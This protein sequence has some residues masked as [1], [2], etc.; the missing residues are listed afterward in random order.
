MTRRDR[1]KERDMRMKAQRRTTRLFILALATTVAAGGAVGAWAGG[2]L[3]HA[4]PAAKTARAAQGRQAPIWV[5]GE[6]QRTARGHAVRVTSR[7]PGATTPR[8]RATARPKAKAKVKAKVKATTTRTLTPRNATRALAATATI[9]LCATAGTVTIGTST[10]P[11]WGFALKGVAANC[12]G[13]TA[14]LPGP[15]LNV[16]QG[17]TVTLAIT[18]AL[19]GS[20]TISV[21]APG[22]AF[23]AGSLDAAPG[24]TVSA[25]FT[26]GSEGTY[27]YESSGDAGRQEAMGLYGALV[28]HSATAGQAYGSAFD[29][30]QVVVLSELDANLNASPDTF[31]MNNWDPTYW[32]LNGKASPDTAPIGAAAGQRVLLRYANAGMDNNT[33]TLLGVR[34]RLI[35]RDAYPLANPFSVVSETFA[36]GQTAD[37]LVT[38]PASASSGAKFALYSRQLRPGMKTSIVVP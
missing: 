20:H 5:A 29:T 8:A 7:H 16:T 6:R 31:D 13:V 19:P 37:A 21:E 17:D 1:T 25:T 3:A 14:T 35:A 18:N 22:I 27:L 12:S 36:S 4:D 34:E 23:A 10:I 2:L 32:L 24:A 38:V 28:V 15:A 30:E 26:A 33:M 11:I 9:E